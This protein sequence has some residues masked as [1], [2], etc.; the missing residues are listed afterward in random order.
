M[1]FEGPLH[2]LL[3]LA[4]AKKIDIARVSVGEIADQYLAFIAEARAANIEIAG[5]YLVMAAWLALLKSRLLIPKP[6]TRRRMS[7]TRCSWRR[8]CARS[9][10]TSSWRARRPSGSSD[11]AARPRRVPERPAANRRCSRRTTVWRAD[12]YDLL[13]AYCAER[14]KSVRK[15]AYVTSV[16]RAYPLE[17]GAQEARAG[18]GAARRSGARIEA[19]TPPSAKR[20]RKRRRR[21]VLSWHPRSAR[22]W[23]WRA[24]AR[25][26]CARPRRSRRCSCAAKPPRWQAMSADGPAA[27]RSPTP[28]AGS[29]TPSRK[30]RERR[31]RASP[32]RRRDPRRRG[33]A[34]CRRRAR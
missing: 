11:A 13:N 1:R 16:R 2:L 9:S 34:V 32:P 8:R 6:Q 19:L 28:C 4:R 25:W 14:A 23:N 30:A 22:R 31:A 20:A 26:N 21:R 3:E 33:A 15:R 5:D 7:P 29:R 27:P 17:D 24:K 18:A 12:L 10:C